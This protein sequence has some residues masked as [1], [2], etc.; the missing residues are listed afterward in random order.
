MKVTLRKIYREPTVEGMKPRFK[1][2]IWIIRKKKE[3]NQNSKKL[4]T[5]LKKM[6]ENFPSLA[7]EIDIQVQEAQRIPNK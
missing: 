3:F 2:M 5:Y 4:K 6:K 1:L 7:K